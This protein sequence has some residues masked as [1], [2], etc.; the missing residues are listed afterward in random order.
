MVRQMRRSSQE[1]TDAETLE[2][3]LA[4]A[5][6]GRLATVDEDGYPVIKPVNFVHEAGK[7]Y[8]HCAREGE[9][10]DDIRRD[11][12]VGFE[13]D[14]VLGIVPT[15]GRGCQTSCLY[16]SVIIRGRARILDDD[17]DAALK[18]RALEL[19]IAKYSSAGPEMGQAE[20]DACLVV[21]ITI[22]RLSGKEAR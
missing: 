20:V 15:T 7:V 21:E 9:K 11:S 18:R 16:R 19:I 1:V 6:V 2:R 3:W 22:E 13:M 8:F 17:A 12:R 4:E 10:L 5:V 14:E